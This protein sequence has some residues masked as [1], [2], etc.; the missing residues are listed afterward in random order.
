MRVATKEIERIKR[1]QYIELNKLKKNNEKIM[2]TKRTSLKGDL[3]LLL[4]KMIEG[5]RGRERD[6]T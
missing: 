3:I 6:I 4:A 2:R 5:N 1:H